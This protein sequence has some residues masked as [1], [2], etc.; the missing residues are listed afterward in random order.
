M[1]EQSEW[2]RYV[3]FRTNV[4]GALATVERNS[5]GDL[6]LILD[7]GMGRHLTIYNVNA[8]MELLK[9]AKGEE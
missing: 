5:K 1:S 3:G 9:R 7:D 6:I 2:E 4:M 8:L